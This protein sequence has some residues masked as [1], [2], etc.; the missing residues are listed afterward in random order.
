MSVGFVFCTHSFHPTFPSVVITTHI[1]LHGGQSQHSLA[2]GLVTRNS[3]IELK[4]PQTTQPLW[5]HLCRLHRIES[6]NESPVGTPVFLRG[7]EMSSLPR[8]VQTRA[9]AGGRNRRMREK[10]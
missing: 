5:G 8:G 3:S 2:S 7:S 1:C 10:N 9:G 6:L 4:K